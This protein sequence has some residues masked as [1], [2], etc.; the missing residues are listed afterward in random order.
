MLVLIRMAKD[1]E[2]LVLRTTGVHYLRLVSP[3]LVF[4]FAATLFAYYFNDIVVPFANRSYEQTL[5]VE[6]QRLPAPDLIE[7]VVFKDSDRFFYIKSVQKNKLRDVII[8]ENSLSFPRITTAKQAQWSGQSW[9][10]ENGTVYDIQHDTGQL[11]YVNRFNSATIYVN[12]QL[13]TFLLPQKAPH[14]MDSQELQKEIA[15]LEKGGG[16]PQVLKVEFHLKR[17]LP[18]ACLIFGCMGVGLC[19]WLV[20]T[21]RDWWGVI[22]AIGTAVLL[23]AFYF[24]L[25]AVLRALSKDNAWN[26]MLGMWLPNMVYFIIWSGVITV[27]GCFRS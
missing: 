12:Q 25:V 18:A 1:N 7:N 13:A 14:E 16:N 19:M 17:S 21:G 23:T 8:F 24:F 27:K 2:L 4:S 10:L 9:I 26:P 6:V 11:N 20:Q 15:N 5:R 3:L 22:I